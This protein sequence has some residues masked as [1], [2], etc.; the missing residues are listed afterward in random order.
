MIWSTTGGGTGTTVIVTESVCGPPGPVTVSVNL[1]ADDLLDPGLTERIAGALARHG[2]PGA[3]L[4][5][6][7]TE[8]ALVADPAAAAT[9]LHGW[10]QLGVT[11]ALDDFGT[12]YSSLSCLHRF[13]IGGLKIDQSF[14]RNASGRRDYAACQVNGRA[15]GVPSCAGSSTVYTAIC[16]PSLR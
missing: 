12:G 7:L 3:A 5:V 13:P 15:A 8:E 1:T 2:L 10:R 9:L 4:H 6:E 14:I 16:P 11:V